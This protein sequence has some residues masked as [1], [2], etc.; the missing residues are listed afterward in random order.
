MSCLACGGSNLEAMR[1][2]NDCDQ[3]VHS[4]VYKQSHVRTRISAGAVAVSSVHATSPN[5]YHSAAPYNPQRIAGVPARDDPMR[6]SDIQV[7]SYKQ[8]QESV[9]KLNMESARDAQLL[10]KLT[11]SKRGTGRNAAFA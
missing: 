8:L 2:C 4:I 3:I 11:A 6:Q 5:T 1:F 10:T 9:R 7:S